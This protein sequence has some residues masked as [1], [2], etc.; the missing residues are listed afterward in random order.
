MSAQS[1]AK[2]DTPDSKDTKVSMIARSRPATWSDVVVNRTFDD[3]QEKKD[4]YDFAAVVEKKEAR[5]LVVGDSDVVADVLIANE[6]N[7]VF[8][9]EAFTWLLRDDRDAGAAVVVNDDAP[10][11]HTRDEDSLW[12]YGTVFGGPAV[13]LFL[14]LGSLRL[15][16]K[17]PTPR[18]TT[19]T[20]TKEGGA[21]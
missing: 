13:V 21:A 14:G 1:L 10:I 16:R 12:F 19:T 8:A 5:A 17:K 11:R 9:Y 18:A 2:N 6:A 4:I 15:R 3:G 20:T 7:A